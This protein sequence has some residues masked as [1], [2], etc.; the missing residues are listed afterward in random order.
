MRSTAVS[1]RAKTPQ[2][3]IDMGA[4]DTDPQLAYQSIS[5]LVI[6]L[7]FF[8]LIQQAIHVKDCHMA[9]LQ[10]RLEKKLALK[11]SNK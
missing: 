8:F 9:I 1:A 7:Y 6:H 10:S 11:S 3:S 2:I 5:E 4:R